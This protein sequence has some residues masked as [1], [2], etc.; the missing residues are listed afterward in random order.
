MRKDNI[1]CHYNHKLNKL[2]NSL[3][4]E[5]NEMVYSTDD[6]R[7]L[8]FPMAGNDIIFSKGMTKISIDDKAAV[9]IGE[10]GYPVRTNVRAM[11]K[12]LSHL[13]DVN[14][15]RAMD[16]DYHCTSLH[17]SMSLVIAS[18]LQVDDSWHKGIATV[19][20]KDGTTQHSTAI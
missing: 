1:D 4:I 15:P 3:I 6:L 14:R 8:T 20:L 16:H 17:P 5:I 19:V 10:P 18:P 7:N 11:S 13:N 2:L 9:H 12:G